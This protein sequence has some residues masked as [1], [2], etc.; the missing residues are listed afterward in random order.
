[1]HLSN[2]ESTE[3]IFL[4]FCR[5]III[6]LRR[7]RSQRGRIGSLLWIMLEFI[8]PP[9]LELIQS[10]VD[11][12][13]QT[14]LPRPTKGWPCETMGPRPFTRSSSLLVDPGNIC[15]PQCVVPHVV[16]CVVT[17]CSRVSHVLFHVCCARSCVLCVSF[18]RD[19]MLRAHRVR[20]T[21][22]FRG[23]RRLSF[24]HVARAVRTR[25]SRLSRS[26][27]VC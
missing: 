23:H 13:C 25:H 18:V 10:C 24:T 12:F 2:S 4:L 8:G 11:P 27:C 17:C 19:V 14:F 21:M 5:L 6:Q 20:A 3:L 16:V 7:L 15:P 26:V 1:V 22:L 9:G